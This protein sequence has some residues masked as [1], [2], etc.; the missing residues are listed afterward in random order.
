MSANVKK[1]T[2]SSV[3]DPR[4]LQVLLQSFYEAIVELQGIIAKPT[5]ESV[6]AAV[7]PTAIMVLRGAT[8]TL[9]GSAASFTADVYVTGVAT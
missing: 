5:P 3:A 7:G 6:A 1:P 2:S 4:A 8:V 9:P